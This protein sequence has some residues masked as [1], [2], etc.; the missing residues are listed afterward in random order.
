[1]QTQLPTAFLDTDAGR[2]ADAIL[3]S[4][5]HC[6]FCTA[7]CPT[8]QLLGDELDGPRGRI[9]LI[10][11]MLEGA[12]VTPKTQLH[13]DRCLTCRAC[14]TT[15]P[16]GVR[17]GRLLDIG[18]ER[19]EQVVPR[20]LWDRVQRRLLLA[21][22]ARRSAFKPLLAAAR[23]VRPLLSS[24]LQSR[25]PDKRA[26]GVWPAAKHARRMLVLQGCV[27]PDAIPAINAA[28]ARVL[29]RQGISLIAVNDGCCGAMAHHLSA[30]ELAHEHMRRNIDAW[31]PEIERGVEAIVVTASGC[32]AMVHEY[33]ELL[34]D[35]SAYAAKARRVSEL[36]RDLSEVIVAASD[37]ASTQTRPLRIAFQSPCTLQHG[38]KIRGAVER[39]LRQRGFQLVPVA[40]GHLCCGSAGTYSLLQPELSQQLRQ[41]KL[42]ALGSGS[43]DVIASANIGCMLHLQAGTGTPVRHWIELLDGAAEELPPPQP[44]PA[45]QGSG[46][47]YTANGKWGHSSFRLISLRK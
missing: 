10:K 19:V 5:V 9:Y 14:E 36:Y 34:R 33:G 13:L 17:Y 38:L 1:M 44:S 16:S 12:P 24:S 31:W 41:N 20:G 43:P 47:N 15:C 21:V 30:A 29:D 26:A 25:V 45:S 39:L 7:T 23:L 4:C 32:G 6:G 11:E 3:R 22:L 40:D 37:G 2:E 8:Y 18:R 27:Q 46:K 28:A 35:D 42:E